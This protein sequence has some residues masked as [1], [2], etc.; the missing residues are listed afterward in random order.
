VRIIRETWSRGSQVAYW[1]APLEVTCRE[2]FDAGFLIERL[3]EPRPLPAAAAMN[4]AHYAELSREPSGF[5]AFRL[6]P[7]Q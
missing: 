6:L 2:I 3:T 1:L 5:L 7:R 4:P